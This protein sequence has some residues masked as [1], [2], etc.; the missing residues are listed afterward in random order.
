MKFLLISLLRA[1]ISFLCGVN[2]SISNAS[3]KLIISSTAPGV[4]GSTIW[5]DV[6]SSI[7]TFNSLTTIPSKELESEE[8]WWY[9]IL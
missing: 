1:M 8:Q 2:L 4:I 9:S 7:A 6:P 5:G 3:P